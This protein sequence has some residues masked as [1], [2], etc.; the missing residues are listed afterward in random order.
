MNLKKL[1]LLK[2]S[3]GAIEKSGLERQLLNGLG[4]G[5]S[6]EWEAA[7]KTVDALSSEE[8]SALLGRILP[9]YLQWVFGREAI[10][11]GPRRASKMGMAGMSGLLFLALITRTDLPGHFGLVGLTASLACASVAGYS[12]QNKIIQVKRH[13][14]R[15]HLLLDRINDVSGVPIVLSFLYENL[16]GGRNPLLHQLS[17]LLVRLLPRVQNEDILNWTPT[18]KSMLLETLLRQTASGTTLFDER[19]RLEAIR[20][21]EFCGSRKALQVVESIAEG[22]T[23]WLPS[24]AMMH[25]SVE[26]LPVLK[27]R[28]EREEQGLTLLR[29]AAAPAK[30]ETLL[31]PAEGV[32]EVDQE[33]LLRPSAQQANSGIEGRTNSIFAPPMSFGKKGSWSKPEVISGLQSPFEEERTLARNAFESLSDTLKF[34][35]IV[36]SLW[37]YPTSKE[38]IDWKKWRDGSKVR[39]LPG[40]LGGAVSLV[41]LIAHPEVNWVTLSLFGASLVG[42]SQ[43]VNQIAVKRDAPALTTQLELVSL[44]D[45]SSDVRLV[46]QFL[47]FLDSSSTF[48]ASMSPLRRSLGQALRR[49]MPLVTQDQYSRWNP[50]SKETLITLVTPQSSLIAR[51]SDFDNYD[52]HVETLRILGMDDS[53]SVLILV[54]RLASKAENPEVREAALISTAQIRDRIARNRDT[55]SLLRGSNPYEDNDNLLRPA[56]DSGV[57]NPDELLRCSSKIGSDS[58]PISDYVPQPELERTQTI[59]NSG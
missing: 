51:Q 12:I 38:Q 26:I 7:L 55:N 24:S 57:T 2:K 29:G 42:I 45:K 40:V 32:F 50:S 1:K 58:K 34:A 3:T 8:R 49:L 53:S 18:Q 47:S 28:I 35:V 46:P 31:R 41:L 22:Q 36:D 43:S 33:E 54:E 52:L 56:G 59:G 10:E 11:N 17:E 37:Q 15:F 13:L 9:S 48:C 25:L 21:L 44:I 19:I 20:L 4:D 27:E 23:R 6:A 16:P 39:F 5:S 14:Q 30:S